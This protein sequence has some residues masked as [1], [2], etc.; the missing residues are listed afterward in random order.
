MVDRKLSEIIKAMAGKMP[1]ISITGP[2]QSGKTTLAKSCFSDYT[3][4]NLESPETRLAASAD[5]KSFLK[6]QGKGL[7]IDEVQRFPE[8]FSWLQVTSDASGRTGEFILTGSQNFLLKQNIS[9]SLAGRVFISHLLPFSIS[10]LASAS[11]LP[12]DA[13]EAMLKG[14]YPRVYDR[15][16]A[17]E[18]FYPSYNQ[19]YLER[20]IGEMV[21]PRNMNLFRRFM[22]L[23]AGRTGQL[24]NFSSLAIEVGVDHKT[25]QSWCSLLET[26]FM[27]FFLRPW[28]VN[29]SKRIVKTPKVYFYDTGLAA[30]LL[31][32]RSASELRRH[33][34]RGALFENMVIADI[35][36]NQSHA[37]D[38]TPLYFWRDNKGVEIDL[39]IA[40]A[41]ETKVIEIKSGSTI[42][43]AFFANLERFEGYADRPLSKFVIYGG[44]QRQ[45]IR[46]T[47]ALPWKNVDQV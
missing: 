37:A 16:I 23:L 17:P 5:P 11:L 20:D 26:G 45:S 42:N 19:T 22:E 8:L 21:N 40:G 34:A 25:I 4:V 30:N 29:F 46:G 47:T 36:K 6:Y 43:P 2:R 32:I 41:V 33:W 27:I 31:G 39:V 10:E 28:F 18:L 1:V 12:A 15:D 9:Q 3:Y 13:D 7:I 14:F 38:Q 24:I 44:D 35:L